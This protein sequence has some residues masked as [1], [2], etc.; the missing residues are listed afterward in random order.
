MLHSFRARLLTGFGIV[1][2]LTLMLSASAVA[3]LLRDQQA[4]AAEARIGL[5]VGPITQLARER[6]LLGWPNQL[7]RAELRAVA[8]LYEIRM[9]LLDRND[10]VAVDTERGEPLVGE[11]L[12]LSFTEPV[13]AQGQMAAFRTQRLRVDGADLYLFTAGETAGTIQDETPLQRLVIAVPAGDVAGAWATLL[14]RL[15]IAG[16]GAAVVAVIFALLFASRITTPIAQMTR[17]S[18]AMG[19]GDLDQR[20]DVNGGDEVGRL[21]EAFNTMSSRLSRSDRSMRDLL[22]NVSHE[23]RTPLTSIQGFSLAIT[24]GIAED[25][26]EAAALINDEAERIRLL[27]DDLLYLS[28]IES[29]T[30]H[31]EIEDVDLDGLI[32]GSVRRFRLQAEERGVDLV[33]VPGGGTIRAD[34]RRLEQVLAN[35]VDNAIRFTPSGGAVTVSAHQVADGALLEVHNPGDPIPEEDRQRVFDR[36]YQVD[37]AR[38]PGRHRGLGLAIVHELV[39]AHGGTVSVD[40]ATERGTTFSVFLPLV[41]HAAATNDAPR[42]NGDAN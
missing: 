14:P 33:P 37:R 35:L 4:E 15:A 24:D 8:D 21:A 41:A 36:F 1:I 28:E 10:R 32:E 2:L 39:Q 7:I 17:A 13:D 29:G 26:R 19:R 42:L 16:L 3:L 6:E 23:L 11:T 31:L 20:I 25:P 5:L 12:A 38:S 22:A 18:E 9:L 27:V 30:V 34:G 40:S